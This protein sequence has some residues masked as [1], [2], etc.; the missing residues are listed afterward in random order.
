[1]SLIARQHR[2][3][4]ERFFGDLKLPGTGLAGAATLSAT[5]RW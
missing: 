2:N 5:L 4:L 1:M 3:P